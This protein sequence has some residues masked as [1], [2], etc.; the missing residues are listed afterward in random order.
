[1][2][3]FGESA[4]DKHEGGDPNQAIADKDARLRRGRRACRTERLEH[5]IEKRA[6]QT[7]LKQHSADLEI[8]HL[9][10]S[11]ILGCCESTCFFLA[12]ATSR[13][14]FSSIRPIGCGVTAPKKAFDHN[15]LIDCRSRCGERPSC[16]ASKQAL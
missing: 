1:M 15:A 7:H 14:L 9:K 2:G 4:G 6:D 8:N 3:E 12:T 11:R 13:G 10:H 5:D 16:K